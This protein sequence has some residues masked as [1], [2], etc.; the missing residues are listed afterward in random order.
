MTRIQT[1]M[2][3]D[4]RSA[5]VLLFRS[6]QKASVRAKVFR[7][8]SEN[9]N[10]KVMQRWFGVG[11]YC[12]GGL[13][14]DFVKRIFAMWGFCFFFLGGGFALLFF[15]VG[16]LFQLGGLGRDLLGL[17]CGLFV[18]GVCILEVFWGCGGFGFLWLAGYFWLDFGGFDGGFL[19]GGGW[20]VLRFF[21]SVLVVWGFLFVFLVDLWFVWFGGCFLLG[22]V[23]F[24][25][26][27]LTAVGLGWLFW[28]GGGVFVW[29][30][31]FLH[32]TFPPDPPLIFKPVMTVN[33]SA[34][35]SF[36]VSNCHV[37]L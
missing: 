17:F 30:A 18:Q 20:L 6:H 32:T 35:V 8:I 13:G 11:L 28:G 24:L 23:F 22:W 26:G 31:W 15:W 3:L 36:N 9:H 14:W 19:G 33:S 10:L 7:S 29:V 4:L 1:T 12:S 16:F 27:V 34:Q 37:L 21:L 2:Q 25:G 5:P